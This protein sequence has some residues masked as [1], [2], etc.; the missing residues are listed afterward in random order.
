MEDLYG[1]I[2]TT[3]IILYIFSIMIYWDLLGDI[4]ITHI[5]SLWFIGIYWDMGF[6]MMYEQL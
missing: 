5:D 4:G 1:S 6:K 3:D 2:G